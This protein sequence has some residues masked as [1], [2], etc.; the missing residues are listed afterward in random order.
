MNDR[1]VTMECSSDVSVQ[2]EESLRVFTG[3][4]TVATVCGGV[5]GIIAAAI[6]YVF[7]LKSMLLSRKGYDARRLFEGEDLEKE[8]HHPRDCVSHSVRAAPT[9]TTNEKEKKQPPMNSDVAAFASR[10][11]VVY[12][13]NQKY[14]PLADGASNPSL[15]EPSKPPVPANGESLSG[16]SRDSLSQDL[17]N[18]D[19][20]QFIS[21]SLVPKSLQNESFR[22]VANY[23]NTLH[24]DSFEG[25][26]S[27]YCLAL[28]DVQQHCSRVQEEKRLLFLHILRIILGNRFP[29]D[30]K[31][32]AFYDDVLLLQETELD[33]LMK[34][35]SASQ[36]A[37][38]RNT[39]PGSDPCTLE[40]I[41]RTQ[42]DLL[43]HGFQMTKGFSK[44]VETFCQSLLGR[45]SVLPRDE[46]QEVIRTVIYC[47]LM[48]E[49]QL[50]E[51]QAADMKRIQERLLWWEEIRGM[52]QVKPA[53]LRQEASLRHSL[54]AR[55]LEQLT[56]DG[57]MT[58]A[59]METT[60]TEIQ[61]ALTESL[62]NCREECRLKTKE[63]VY[64]RCKKMD[65]KKKKLLSTQGKERSCAL[66][67]AKTHSDPQEFV[68]V[69]QVLLLRQRKQSIDLELQ[70]DGKVTEVVFDLWR[71]HYAAWS[72]RLGDVT[73]D[74]FLSALPAQSPLSADQGKRLWLNQ[75]GDLVA[76]QQQAEGH[77]KRQLECLQAQ[78]K[79]DGLIWSEETALVLSCLRHLSEQQ[80]K[81]LR[82]MVVR[83]SYM[84]NSHVGMLIE[85]K[86]HL[87][88]EAIQR[89]L[90]ARHFCLRVLK[91]MR[92]S[93]LKFLSQGTDSKALLA[94]ADHN[95]G[96]ATASLTLLESSHQDSSASV[97][98]RH[99]GPETQLIGHSLQQEFL[100]E[101]ETASE[102]LQANVQLLVGHALSQSL[103]QQMDLGVTNGPRSDQG[104][105]SQLTE[106]ASESVYVTWD[107][108]SGVVT[109]YYALIQDI[110]RSLQPQ[111]SNRA[112]EED[113]Q[114]ESSSQMNK[115]L[116]KELTNWGRKP[117][118]A[119]FQKRVEL[120]KK[121]MLEQ[122]DLEQEVACET[123][124]R[125]KVAQEQATEMFKRQLQEAEA[126]FI[127]KLSSLARIPL[128]RKDLNTED[129]VIGEDEN[130]TLNPTLWKRRERREH[131][132][133]LTNP[134]L[135]FS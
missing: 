53:L 135:L 58:F 5:S 123:L 70:Q 112:R 41:E 73:K 9:A 104:M 44:Q 74:I 110:T 36:S 49:N 7:C 88:L 32:S 64:E 130:P 16:S 47:L 60:L 79:Q 80:L 125:R 45:S 52:L 132:T 128:S 23:P 10:A 1:D 126:D 28:Q 43:E 12:P 131:E 91:E 61:A 71:R 35:L 62:Q 76:L 114:C 38:E 92:L 133:L 119:E 81:I 13:I 67:S 82:C 29:K 107:S 77:A 84:L 3:L 4:L 2:F 134:A 99:L 118:S 15:H 94:L 6:L 108:L 129:D 31:E 11:K 72:K 54:V 57:H 27:L 51:M 26:I 56:S 111:D 85:K 102:L 105:K 87:L 101:L 117:M 106:V 39:D 78:L 55:G 18:D 37:W 17:D 98:E 33:S 116:L 63:L 42:K 25:R 122:H 66:G 97:A 75:E 103:W 40:E 120:Q 46:A 65:S 8:N 50:T 86:Q 100:S 68:K 89:H 121:R 22:R 59:T 69:Y 30:K 109:N 24:Q 14:R 93:K 34:A 95:R 83:Q 113:K 20:S 115:Y 127:A 19:S 124:R 21:S 90:V 96:Q 48:V